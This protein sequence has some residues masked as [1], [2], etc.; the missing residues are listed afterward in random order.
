[1]YCKS[2][3]Y[4]FARYDAARLAP[5]QEKLKLKL[6]KANPFLGDAWRC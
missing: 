6:V 1:M 5:D 3:A 2:K 4:A